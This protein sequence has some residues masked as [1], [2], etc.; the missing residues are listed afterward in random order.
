MIWVVDTCVILDVL[1][2]DPEFGLRSARLL[3]QRLAEGL[4]ICPVTHVELAPAFGGDLGAQKCF[5]DQAGIDY[6]GGWT[7]ADTEAAHR[8]WHLHVA[9]RRSGTL[10]KHPIAD[11]LIG[12]FASNRRGLITRNPRDFRNN[13]PDLQILEPATHW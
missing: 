2:D 12:A 11:I 7:L 6:R 4:G 3:E 10:A 1:E 8:A 5:L 9:A 13:F